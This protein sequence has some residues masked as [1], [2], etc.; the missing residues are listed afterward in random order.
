MVKSAARQWGAVG[1]TVN[2]VLVPVELLAP[3]TAGATSFLP[4]PA[5][6]RARDGRR[7]RRRG[8][9]VR[10]SGSPRSDRRD[11]GR[12]RRIGDGT[13][14][15]VD[16]VGAHGDRHGWC[17][18]RRAAASRWRA[19]RRVRTSS[20]PAGARTASTWSTRS[21]RAAVRRR[22]RSATSP[23]AT[24]SRRT[25][26]HAVERTG[27]LHAIVH[28]ATSNRSSEPHRLEDVTPELWDA[29]RRRCRCAAP[30]TAR[31]PA[32]PPCRRRRGTL[33]VMTSP[34]GI[35]GSAT[36]P[37][38]ATMKGALRGF[39][40]SLAREWAPHGVTVNVVS[41][42]AF[43]PAMVNAIA[44]DP[45]MEDRL[46]RRVPLGSRRRSGDRCGARR[47]VPPERRRRGTSPARPSAST[48]ATS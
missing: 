21:W 24:P 1:I 25:V 35:E 36:L 43:S 44:E 31:S 14:S 41:P 17:G 19:A 4:P 33:V 22:G 9:S 23:T 42:L 6:G 7:R 11:R 39:A 16:L 12:R 32:C 37:L 48:A 2:T 40:K 18:R 38:Y 34:A 45:D 3:A 47:R 26:A 27:G 30:T 5:L 8:G 28:N 10:R 20:S 29:A 15:A 46:N 13:V